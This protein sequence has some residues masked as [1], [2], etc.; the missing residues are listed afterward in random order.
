MKRVLFLIV[1]AALGCLLFLGCDK[2]ESVT[3]PDE[4][5]PASPGLPD[6]VALARQFAPLLANGVDQVEISAT[7]VDRNGRGLKDVGVRFSTNHGTVEPFAT[8]DAE[9]VARTSLTSEASA[10]DLVATITAVAGAD[11]VSQSPGGPVLAAASPPPGAVVVLSR[12]PLSDRLRTEAAGLAPASQIEVTDQVTIRMKGITLNL[13]ASPGTIPAD[14]LSVSRITASVIETTSRVPL[15]D[16]EVR[17]GATAGTITGHASTDLSGTAA[18]TLTGLA[19][20]STSTITAFYGNTLTA[21]TSVVFSALTLTLEPEFA[22]QDADG[23]SA[24]TMVAQLVNAEHNPVAGARIDFTTTLGT[25]VSPVTTDA[26]GEARTQLISGRS[27]G[28]AQV[29]ARFAALTR[30]A[31]VTLVAPPVTAEILLSADPGSLPA[32]GAAEATLKAIALNHAGVPMADGTQLEF[33]IVSGSGKIISPRQAMQ[34]GEAKATYV[35]GTTPG[36]VTLSV[37]SGDAT[38][39]A[40]LVL[41]PLEAGGLTLTAGTASIL[42]DGLASTTLTA[43]VTDQFGNPVAPGTAVNF[44]TSL[45][46]IESVTPTSAAGIATA[47]LRAGRFETG[48]A[49]VTAAVGS[50]QRTV[51]VQFVSEAAHHIVIIELDQPRIGVKGTGSPQTATLTF[52]VRDRNGIPVDAAHAATVTFGIVPVGG[53]TDA[54]LA[55]N[56]ALTNERGRVAAVVRSGTISGAVEVTA[57]IGA[58]ISQPIRVAIHGDLPDPDHFSIAFERLNIAGLVYDGIRDPV[59]AHVGDQHGNPVPD[60]TAV[61]FSCAYGLIQGSSFTNDHAEATVDHITAAPRPDIPGGDGLVLITAQ[62]VSKAG[63][64]ITTSGSV[65][66]SGP[67][68]LE[69]TDP[70][71]AAGFTVANGGSVTIRFRV[72]DAN[73]NPI[74]G[75]STI[76]AKATSGDL[77]GDTD[78]TMP[79]TQSDA[80]TYFSVTL[81]DSDSGDTDPPRRATVTIKVQSQNGNGLVS[82]TGTVD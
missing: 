77:G 5:T 48:L 61:W 74:V 71:P 35:A 40:Q 54:T 46:A 1:V 49:R 34:G 45:G 62:T 26:K 58:I 39:T 8:T 4:G 20:G 33:S 65:L 60:S 30:S 42:A 12:A 55:V 81:S 72:R 59:T 25:I 75:G 31:S 53:D 63:N 28:T 76:T 19:S 36:A 47:R 38:K 64:L 15:D 18:A 13:A 80:Y 27:T 17:F 7:V 22:A 52:E 73:N 14:G 68:I 79:D 37:S 43:T 67:T 2:E 50:L 21:Q 70:L 78:F 69:I 41:T 51:D 11:T 3:T 24:T 82:I 10:A 44:T 6:S 29:T 57:S 66:W 23:V 56:S 32:D 16:Q 9:G